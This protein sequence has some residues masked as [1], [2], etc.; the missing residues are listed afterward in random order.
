[1]KKLLVIKSLCLTCIIAGTGGV[2]E[3]TPFTVAPDAV[4]RLIGGGFSS[5][6]FDDFFSTHS[7]SIQKTLLETTNS[8]FLAALNSNIGP[9]SA[10]ESYRINSAVLEVGSLS[11]GYATSG[12]AGVYEVLVS[13]NSATVTWNTFNSGGVAGI[14]YK[15]TSS[16]T[17]MV[18]SS[19][20]TWTLTSMVQDW[21]DG[22][23][24]NHG[25]YFADV[26]T[27]NFPEFT[28]KANVVWK[29]DATTVPEP[30]TFALL[31]L[32]LGVLGYGRKKRT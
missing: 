23:T 18:G 15:V 6:H 11:D 10:G 30:S 12:A 28:N 25:L 27:L 13:Y 24:I 31:G 16:A 14:D 22:S 9:I 26:G 3:A 8:T 32:G 17:G 1:M 5:T 19:I 21:I 2:V 7:S 20:T 4:N 29:I